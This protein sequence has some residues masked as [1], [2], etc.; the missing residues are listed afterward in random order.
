MKE[1]LTGWLFSAEWKLVP[2]ST[3]KA[4]PEVSPS[5]SKTPLAVKPAEKRSEK[6]S[7]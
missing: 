5:W 1:N 4:L 3:A 6:F 2:K 7:A